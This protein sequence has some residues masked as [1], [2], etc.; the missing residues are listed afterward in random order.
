MIWAAV[1]SSTLHSQAAVGTIPHLCTVERNKPTPV[2]RRLGLTK[3]GLL[4]YIPNGLE[5]G[6]KLR[7]R[8][9]L[10]CYSVFH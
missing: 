3:D 2:R 5:L 4:R 8:E 6:I 1:S 10:L 9:V 7:M